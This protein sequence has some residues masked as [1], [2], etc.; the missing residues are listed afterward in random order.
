MS[1]DIDKMTLREKL[2]EADRLLRELVDHLDN[3]FTPKARNLS[4]TIQEHGTNEAQLT[5][6]TIRQHAADLI[7]DNRF[8]ERLFQKIGTLLYSIDQDVSAIQNEP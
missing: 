4:R 6:M 3:G 8:S 1:D 7:D 2:S 5:D